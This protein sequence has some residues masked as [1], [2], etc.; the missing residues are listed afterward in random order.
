MYGQSE[1][2]MTKQVTQQR[3]R[4]FRAVVEHADGKIATQTKNAS[5][6]SA[7]MAMISHSPA[8]G[9]G[10]RIAF[11]NRTKLILLFKHCVKL[12]WTYPKLDDSIPFCRTLSA[13]RLQSARTSRFSAE[14]FSNFNFPTNGTSFFRNA[15]RWRIFFQ[16][17]G[18]S[19]C[20]LTATLLTDETLKIVETGG[21]ISKAADP[22]RSFGYN[23]FGQ[24]VNLHNR[25]AN[26]LGSM[27]AQTAFEPSVS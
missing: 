18:T 23:D 25:F 1:L 8:R 3:T 16:S 12:L 13:G 2:L 15:Y 24:G 27:V 5:K 22:T 20:P 21:R 26:W 4:T 9:D 6:R 11:A 17:R 19:T 7:N 14:F 10:L